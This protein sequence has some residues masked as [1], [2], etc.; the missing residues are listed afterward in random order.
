MKTETVPTEKYLD[1]WSI[2]DRVAHVCL[3]IGFILGFLTGLPTF[4]YGLFGWMIDLVG[5]KTNRAFIHHWIVPAFLG[6]AMIVSVIKFLKMKGT[7]A[8]PTMKDIKDL[9]ALVKR[10]LGMKVEEPELGFHHPGEKFVFLAA[11]ASLIIFAITGPI[12]VFWIGSH[13]LFLWARFFHSLAVML[14][15]VVLAGHFFMAISPSNWPVL[16]AM[17]TNGKVHIKWAKKHSPKWA[18]EVLSE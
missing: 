17:F 3:V 10:W 4:D 13:E 15:M 6:V 14:M 5:G 7:D 16:K 8:F 11:L 12:M 2:W 9:I 18:E 1:R